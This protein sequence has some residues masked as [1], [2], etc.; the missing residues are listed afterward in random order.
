M[1]RNTTPFG[2]RS[3]AVAASVG[4][5]RVVLE[6]HYVSDVAAGAALGTTLASLA[7]VL[8]G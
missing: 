6:L 5:S 7:A 3:R 4:A 1:P 8:A 2:A